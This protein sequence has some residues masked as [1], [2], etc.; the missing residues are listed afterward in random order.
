[1]VEQKFNLLGLSLIV[2]EV[3]DVL[4]KSY[5]IGLAHSHLHLALVDLTQVHHLVN[6]AEY[7]FCIT[8]DGLIDSPSVGVVI[9]LD[10]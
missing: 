7:S 2:E 9:G 8:F 3:V 6:Q 4:Y 1:M 5:K 10:E